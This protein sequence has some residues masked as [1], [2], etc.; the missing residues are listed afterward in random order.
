MLKDTFEQGKR[1]YALPHGPQL[2][3]NNAT[4]GVARPGTCL[5]AWAGETNINSYSLVQR[6]Q[7]S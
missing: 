3:F 4:S 5:Y 1:E 7:Y 2:I 6:K